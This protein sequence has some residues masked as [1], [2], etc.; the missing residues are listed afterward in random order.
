MGYAPSLKSGLTAVA[1]AAATAVL[2]WFGNG[3]DPWWPLMW[4]APLPV[5]WFALRKSGWMTALTAVAAWLAGSLNLWGYFHLIGVPFVAWLGSR[6]G[7]AGGRG[8]GAVVSR[9]GAARRMVERA[10][11]IS[12]D[13]GHARVRAQPDDA[14]CDSRQHCLHAVK[15]SAL[16]ATGL[17]HGTVGHELSAAVL[18]GGACDWPAPARD[19]AQGGAADCGDDPWRR[20]LQC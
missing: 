17:D 20:W 9:V 13:M 11:G 6:R 4:F 8:R 5:L 10:G 14:A 18:S 12:R 16:P 19:G 3:L 2:L 1:A 15:V 7:C